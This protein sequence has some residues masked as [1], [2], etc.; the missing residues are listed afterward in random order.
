M[1]HLTRKK[2][3]GVHFLI[4]Y[5]V[6][7]GVEMSLSSC[8]NQP[9]EILSSHFYTRLWRGCSGVIDIPRV[10]STES[11]LEMCTSSADESLSQ[12]I[13]GMIQTLFS[14]NA[15][16]AW[17][18][19]IFHCISSNCTCNTIATHN[20]KLTIVF[21]CLLLPLFS[22]IWT[23]SNIQRM[24][25]V[26]VFEARRGKGKRRVYKA[27]MTIALMIMEMLSFTWCVNDRW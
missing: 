26:I 23:R 8:N 14:F 20:Q 10:V 18:A 24:C 2:N 16:A 17:Q 6:L 25:V 19:I 9:R 12:L 5:R 13:Q 4:S 11:E 7:F 15:K 3:V 27:C 22:L 21:L 1:I